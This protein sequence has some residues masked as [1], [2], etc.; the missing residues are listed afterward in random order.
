MSADHTSRLHAAGDLMRLGRPG[1]AISGLR[2]LAAEAPALAQAHR[3]LGVALDETGDPMAA[4]S[5][6]R[7]A[8]AAD[9]GLVMAAVGLAEVLRKADRGNEAIEVL[10]RF[11]TEDCADLNLLTY[12]AFALQSVGR[13]DEALADLHRAVATSPASAVAEHNLAGALGDCERCEESE[14]AARRALAKGLDAPE[15]WLVLARALRGQDREEEAR[16]AYGEAILRRAAYPDAHSD[17][18]QMT[19]TRTGDATAAL[20][21][22]DRAIAGP[23]P[24]PA[25]LIHRAKLL[26]YVGDPAGA[27]EALAR[28]LTVSDDAMLHV[29]AAQLAVR[30]DPQRGLAHAQRAFA[31]RPNNYSVMA[32]L[33]QARL[34]VGRPDEAAPLAEALCE[35]Q[36]WDQYAVAL[37][38]TTWRLQGDPRYGEL[39]DYDR[40]IGSFRLDT[41]YGWPSLEAYLGDLHR[42]LEPLHPFRGHPVGQ[43]VRQGSQTGRDLTAEDAPAIKAFFQAIDGPIRRYV[44]ALGEGADPLRRR[45]TGAYR[46]NGV[47]S[48]RLRPS[49]FHV[50]HVHHKGWL[51]S[52][53]Y[54]ALPRAVERGHEG[55]LKFGEPGIP[56]SPALAP[57]RF[58]KPEVGQLILFPSYFWHGTAP[59]SGEETRL[60]IAFDVLP[61]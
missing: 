22:I 30:S 55:W 2:A 58:V 4:E 9:P 53:C 43:S 3:L 45:I 36:S 51:S 40:L 11:V 35:R 8:I 50:D 25:L 26:E 47:W 49:G 34:A 42:A 28:A 61:A 20:A 19:W 21:V 13:F 16:Q 33:C 6:F 1:E 60:S 12:H 24:D 54:V 27:G 38:A 56:T 59:F 39:C 31:L 41:P 17:L 5:A 18:A 15:T 7:D 46:F 29:A 48:V 37:L 44:A 32:A 23:E 52:A 10:A 57:E 14:A